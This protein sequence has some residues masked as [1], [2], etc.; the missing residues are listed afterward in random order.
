MRIGAP[1]E[2]FPGEARVAMTPDSAVALQK[3][4]RPG[5]FLRCHP[6]LHHVQGDEPLL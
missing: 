4:G 5:R 1:R 3:L 6:E 2:V